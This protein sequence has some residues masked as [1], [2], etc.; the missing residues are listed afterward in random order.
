MYVHFVQL[1]RGVSTCTIVSKHLVR[2]TTFLSLR[3][4][5][6]CDLFMYNYYII[7]V[8]QEKTVQFEYGYGF[9]RCLSAKLMKDMEPYIRFEKSQML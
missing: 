4:F 6:L 8:L 1:H 2:K 9:A 7:C 5:Q 3:F